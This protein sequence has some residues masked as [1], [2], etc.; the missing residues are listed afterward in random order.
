[1]A[2]VKLVDA[3][4]LSQMT[5]EMQSLYKDF[6]GDVERLKGELNLCITQ[7]N[8]AK[9]ILEKNQS[10]FKARMEIR[11]ISDYWFRRRQALER[12]FDPEMLKKIQN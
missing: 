3:D 2:S 9:T 8:N 6:F 12:I 4:L 1:M 10:T 5:D 11:R 7:Y